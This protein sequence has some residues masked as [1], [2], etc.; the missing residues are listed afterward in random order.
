MLSA[1]VE[2]QFCLF[3]HNTELI[4]ADFRVYNLVNLL[5]SLNY[6]LGRAG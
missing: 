3:E 6:I 2:F 4:I 1:I 5:V